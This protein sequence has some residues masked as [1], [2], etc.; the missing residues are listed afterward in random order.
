MGL[1]SRGSYS[2]LEDTCDWENPLAWVEKLLESMSTGA[3]RELG[4]IHWEDLCPSGRTLFLKNN[5]EEYA[6][7]LEKWSPWMISTNHHK[8]EIVQKVSANCLI[9]ELVPVATRI[10]NSWLNLRSWLQKDSSEM[11]T[12]QMALFPQAWA[13]K[14]PSWWNGGEGS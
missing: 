11:E 9:S 12:L 14:A 8:Q 3:E 7:D 1:C 4:S 5:Q 13:Y 6:E 10:L 2:V